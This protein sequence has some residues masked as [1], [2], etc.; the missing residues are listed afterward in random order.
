MTLSIDLLYD[1]PSA[2]EAQ[3]PGQETL[4]AILK[5]IQAE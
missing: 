2:P 1:L 5:A 4:D 3:L